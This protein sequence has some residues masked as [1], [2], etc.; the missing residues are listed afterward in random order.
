[1][2]EIASLKDGLVAD[3]N[4]ADT[5]D[6]VEALRIGALGKSGDSDKQED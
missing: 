4:S 5:L 1:M 2:T 6:A 3:I